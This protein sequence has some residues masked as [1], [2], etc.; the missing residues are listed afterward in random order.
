MM[1]MAMHHVGLVFPLA[2]PVHNRYLKSSKALYI[3]IVSVH[4][5]PIKKSVDIYQIKI[6]TQLVRFLFNYGITKPGVAKI[7]AAFVYKFPLVFVKKFCAVHWHYHFS[8]MAN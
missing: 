7:G 5:F 6:E 2:K 8:S 4:F 1:I 3:I